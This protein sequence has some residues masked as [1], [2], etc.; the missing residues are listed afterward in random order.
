M[1]DPAS[2]CAKMRAPISR[3][4]AAIPAATSDR[5]ARG[6]NMPQANGRN[7]AEKKNE[8]KTPTSVKTA[9]MARQ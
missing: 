8:K 5:P 4:G 7:D 9:M 2:A 6:T 3:L 1:I